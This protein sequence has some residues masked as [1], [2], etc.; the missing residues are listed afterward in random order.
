MIKLDDKLT[1]DDKVTRMICARLYDY[2]GYYSYTK[3][4]FSIRVTLA[5]LMSV[6]GHPSYIL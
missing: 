4:R 3:L 1:R 6:P 5:I 2:Q